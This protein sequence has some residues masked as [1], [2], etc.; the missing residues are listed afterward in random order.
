MQDDIPGKI[1]HVYCS[2]TSSF[3]NICECTFAEALY[4]VVV[5]QN[6]VETGLHP[7]KKQN[8]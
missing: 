6:G 5:N 7:R 3:F 4:V 2:F 8:H 1:A